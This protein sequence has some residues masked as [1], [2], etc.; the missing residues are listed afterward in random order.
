MKA[1]GRSRGR[2]VHVVRAAPVLNNSR[3]VHDVTPASASIAVER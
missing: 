1:L 3:D 2:H